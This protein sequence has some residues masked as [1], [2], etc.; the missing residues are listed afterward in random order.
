V[1]PSSRLQPRGELSGELSADLVTIVGNLIENAFDATDGRSK[2]SVDVAVSEEA[3]GVRIQVGDTGP[4]VPLDDVDR[5]FLSG[6]TTKQNAQGSHGVGLALVRRAVDRWGGEITVH[7]DGGAVFQ[8]WLPYAA[9][10]ENALRPDAGTSL[11]PV[12]G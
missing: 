3:G 4:G 5:I 10:S 11:L 12:T 6:F 2:R 8:V 7:T 9:S 1:S